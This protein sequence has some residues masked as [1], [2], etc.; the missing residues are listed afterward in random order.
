MKFCFEM[1]LETWKPVN[2]GEILPVAE[3]QTE[4]DFAKS[5]SFEANDSAIDDLLR[6]EQ[7][8]LKIMENA[9]SDGGPS[10]S[11]RAAPGQCDKIRCRV[12]GHGGKCQRWP[13]LVQ[14]PKPPS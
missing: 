13:I 6:D 10:N 12:C 8:S 2:S 3:N 9:S 11:F 4:E 5:D 14:R 1:K 7:D